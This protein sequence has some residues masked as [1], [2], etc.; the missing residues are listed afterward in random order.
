MIK[1][2]DYVF[3]IPNMPCHEI[4]EIPPQLLVSLIDCLN[5]YTVILS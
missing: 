5:I 3:Y 1:K 4:F 2:W